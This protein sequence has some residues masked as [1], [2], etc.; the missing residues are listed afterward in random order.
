MKTFDRS[1]K[2]QDPSKVA[3]KDIAK[4]LLEDPQDTDEPIDKPV[5][6]L[7]RQRIAT[8]VWNR[9]GQDPANGIDDLATAA[10]VDRTRLVDALADEG[11][12]EAKQTGSRP[13]Q[14]SL[15]LLIVVGLLALAAVITFALVRLDP[16]TLPGFQEAVTRSF[17]GPTLVAFSV[18]EFDTP[19]HAEMGMQALAGRLE[20]EPDDAGDLAMDDLQSI[21]LPVY[22]D[23]VEG[24]QGHVPIG[25]VDVPVAYLLV[26]DGRYVHILQAVSPPADGLGAPLAIVADL[27]GGAP[28]TSLL[29][30]PGPAASAVPELRTGG[31]WDQLPRPGDL[32]DD[33]AVASESTGL[34]R[35]LFGDDDASPMPG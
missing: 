10:K 7:G 18:A 11:V 23:G 17:A 30:T 20:A 26:R 16:L 19:E 2:R 12:Y 1:T 14:Y 25:D 35:A 9:A 24:Y 3:L 32:P 27:F 29:A 13:S 8:I 21:P 4:R 22:R 28:Y 34:N 31:L 5:A 15:E 6:K 33:Y